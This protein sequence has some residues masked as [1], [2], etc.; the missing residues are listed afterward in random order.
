MKLW[1]QMNKKKKLREMLLQAETEARLRG[2]LPV[3]DP[4]WLPPS[5]P[6]PSMTTEEEIRY[7]R[8]MA[9]L[10]YGE[11][12]ANPQYETLLTVG[13]K[14]YLDAY[15]IQQRWVG[16]WLRQQQEKRLPPLAEDHP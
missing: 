7:G 15:V 16:M 12:T 3:D 9:M 10:H 5:M 4:E 6:G 13:E 8:M 1:F 11:E 2:P 14:D